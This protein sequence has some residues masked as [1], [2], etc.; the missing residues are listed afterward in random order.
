MEIVL[1]LILLLVILF[2]FSKN[3]LFENDNECSKIEEGECTSKLC[4]S[5]CKIQHSSISDN[6]YCTQRK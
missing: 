6:C 1:L 3:E 4:P 5:S 2:I